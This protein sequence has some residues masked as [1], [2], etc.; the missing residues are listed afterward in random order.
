M[1]QIEIKDLEFGYRQE[2]LLR[3]IHLSVRKGDVVMIVGENGSGKSTLLKLL[4]GE[5]NAQK[6]SIKLF[7]RGLSSNS[8]FKEVGYVPQVQSFNQVTFPITV[9]EL[10]VLSLYRE[11]GPIKIPR[12]KHR[13]KAIE[14]LKKM[15]LEKYIHTPF[16][17]L[18]GGLKQRTM[19]TRALMNKP[20]ILILDEPTAGVDKESKK[21][22]LNLIEKLNK[23]QHITI[24]IVTHEAGLMKEHITNTRI[25]E[26]RE[27]RL[28]DVGI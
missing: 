13:E 6:G 25:Y 4:L 10:V 26:M 21:E 12:K 28:E 20:E 16:N 3:G 18:S 7:G 1:N 27:G 19:I 2:S 23:E 5:L 11:F 8:S 14:L 9:L 15:G 22:F 24:L 17:E